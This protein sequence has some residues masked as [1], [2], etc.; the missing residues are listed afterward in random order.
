MNVTPWVAGIA[1]FCSTI[2]FGVTVDYITPEDLPLVEITSMEWDAERRAV[3]YQRRVNS[4]TPIRAPYHGDL[5]EVATERA[6][7]ECEVTGRA[8][9]GPGEPDT[10]YFS[11]DNFFAEGCAAALV[12]GRYYE[13][14]GSVS[15]LHGAPTLAKSEPFA[16]TPE[17]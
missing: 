11:L 12:P 3:A 16:W 2:G 8:T 10:Q 13:M 4:P 1:A 14:W 7:E 17:S 6:V 15:P 5:V 9:Y